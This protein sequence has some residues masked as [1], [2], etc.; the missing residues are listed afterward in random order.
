MTTQTDPFIVIDVLANLALYPPAYMS[1]PA[2]LFYARDQGPNGTLY[3]LDI[4]GVGTKSWK[5]VGG[6]GGS[7]SG[8]AIKYVVYPSSW[9]GT[10][11]TNAYT[12]IGAAIAAANG[13]NLANRVPIIVMPGQYNENITLRDGMDLYGI[14]AS[15]Q[16]NFASIDSGPVIAAANPLLAAVTVQAGSKCGISNMNIAGGLE[17]ED[18]PGASKIQIEGCS[19]SGLK[20]GALIDGS[21]ANVDVDVSIRNTSIVSFGKAIELKGT[22]SILFAR[23]CNFSGTVEARKL[24]LYNVV[25]GACTS[26]ALRMTLESCEVDEI[27]A[28]AGVDAYYTTCFGAV[29]IDGNSNLYHCSIDGTS[30]T[31]N[32]TNPSSS[33]FFYCTIE[34]SGDGIVLSANDTLTINGCLIKAFTG[35]AVSGSGSLTIVGH[36]AGSGTVASTITATTVSLQMVLQSKDVNLAGGAVVNNWPTENPD[37]VRCTPPTIVA[38]NNLQA[39]PDSRIQPPNRITYVINVSETNFMTITAHPGSGDKIKDGSL[40]GN[41]TLAP[42]DYRMFV[43][44]R[45]VGWEV[46]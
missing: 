45:G 12:S 26:S 43:C 27:T 21:G 37:R 4:D 2:S 42:G 41:I 10:V 19:F 35:I 14:G 8:A 23:D 17:F 32:S 46:N 20:A 28:N 38:A 34:T 7:I 3:I 25:A 1:N 16:G 24:S 40:T 29:N 33:N 6:A 9:G 36:L 30:I 39:L 11:P 22:S 18:A 15:T 5:P 31:L 13:E 44:I